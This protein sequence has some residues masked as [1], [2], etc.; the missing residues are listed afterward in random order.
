MKTGFPIESIPLTDTAQVLRGIRR[1]VKTNV[2]RKAAIKWLLDLL[3]QTEDSQIRNQ[4]ALALG[5]LRIQAAVPVIINLLCIEATRHNRG[6]LL[7]ALQSLNYQGFLVEIACQLASDEYEVLEMALQLLEQLPPQLKARQT[8]AAISLL[9]QLA[10]AASGTHRA[11]YVNQGL[12]LLQA[13][14][15]PSNVRRHSN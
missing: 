12:R 8:C 15:R 4:A 2:K 10:E 9:Q 3:A 13:F 11:N 5:D 6:S 1:C 7:Y 14:A